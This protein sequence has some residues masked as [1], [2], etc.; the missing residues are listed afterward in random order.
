VADKNRTPLPPLPSLKRASALILGLF[1]K[2]CFLTFGA[3]AGRRRSVWWMWV[4]LCRW[5]CS[6]DGAARQP[7]YFL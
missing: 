5:G 6:F 7:A 4:E 2:P 3:R 1:G